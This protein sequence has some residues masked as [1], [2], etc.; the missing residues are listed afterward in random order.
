[1]PGEVRFRRKPASST[2]S[3]GV[4]PAGDG[5]AGDRPQLRMVPGRFYSLGWVVVRIASLLLLVVTAINAGPLPDLRVQVE[6]PA[7]WQEL[8]GSV[9]IEAT[10][11]PAPFR[12]LVGASERA[13]AVGVVATE[14]RVRVASIVDERNP[15]LKIFWEQPRELPVFALPIDARVFA[16]EKHTNAPL[17]AGI[18][19]PAGQALWLAIEPGER[20]YQRFPYIVHAL[21]DLGLRLPLRGSRTWVF[22]DSSYRLRADPSYLARRWRQAG[23]A[24]VHVAAWHFYDRDPQ[25]ERYLEAL[26]AACRR[27]AVLVYAWLELPHVSEG[28]WRAR[29]DCRE[30]TARGADAELDW[31]KLINL[32]EPTCAEAVEKGVRRLLERFDWDGVNLAEL[33]FESL[34]GPSNAARLTPMNAWV[35]AHAKKELGFDPAELFDESSPLAWARSP[36][37]W[38]RFADYRARLALDLQLQWLD[39]LRETLPEADLVVTQIDDRFDKNMRE[40]LGADTAALLPFAAKYDFTLLIEDPAT[41][42]SHGPERYPEIARRYQPLTNDDARLAIDINIVER[43]QQT[44]PTRKQVGGELFQLASLASGAFERL[45][46]YFESS[47]GRSDWDLL[48]AAATAAVGLRAVGS[49][50]EAESSRWFGVNWRGP[51]VVDGQVWRLRDA[52]TLWLPP[53]RHRI[54]PSGA[55]VVGRVLYLNAEIEAVQSDATSVA[56]RYR[57]RSRTMALLDRPP[58]SI[59]LD[60]SNG[61]LVAQRAG[62]HWTIALPRG[63]H[64]F[65]AR[66]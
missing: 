6:N 25:R 2:L 45:A 5:P 58:R 27:E 4:G 9:G 50:L 23:V 56:M 49:G 66:F 38:V 37:P 53:G 44:Y 59:E 11:D 65:T 42:W 39:L 46:L 34:H 54:E 7:L 35:R 55:D 26:I 40:Y 48:P 18:E 10:R 52:H 33:Y 24:G 1:M 31:R 19:T 29:P 8:L 12:I 28:F 63:S 51:A 64:M 13:R 22:F 16:R 21:V 60:G 57:S 32:A 15:Q 61:S 43:Y 47:I 36:D 17:S 3:F 30:K 62:P 14:A 20:G 41:L